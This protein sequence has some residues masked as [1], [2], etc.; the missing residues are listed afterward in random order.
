MDDYGKK[1]PICY[2]TKFVENLDELSCV[3]CGHILEGHLSQVNFVENDG[4]FLISG[5]CLNLSHRGRRILR[6]E[7][8]RMG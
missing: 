8:Q 7:T 5:C 6:I 1:C 3:T 4:A 2:G